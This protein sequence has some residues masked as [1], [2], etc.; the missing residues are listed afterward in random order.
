MRGRRVKTLTGKSNTRRPTAL[1]GR[2][3]F[4]CPDLHLTCRIR[5]SAFGEVMDTAW[6][7]PRY[8][9]DAPIAE[10][11]IKVANEGLI[12]HTRLM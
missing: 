11:V 6:T 4:I 2:N 3:S 5:I 7:F 10:N 8:P 9:L 1:S 12:R